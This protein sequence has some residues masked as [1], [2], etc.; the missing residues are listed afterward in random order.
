MTFSKRTNGTKKNYKKS[1]Q[2]EETGTVCASLI[3]PSL[4]GPNLIV[5]PGQGIAD[6]DLRNT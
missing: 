1:F 6:V 5:A 3:R 4:I 2:S